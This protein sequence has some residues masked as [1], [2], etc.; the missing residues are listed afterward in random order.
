M[1]KR[2]LILLAGGAIALAILSLSGCGPVQVHASADPVPVNVNGTI[3][4]SVPTSA[5]LPYLIQICKNESQYA[6]C[7]NVDPSICATCL[8]EGMANSVGAPSPIPV[9]SN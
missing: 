1:E 7:Y 2:Y 9:S 4:V 5:Y 6:L 3:Y 8:M